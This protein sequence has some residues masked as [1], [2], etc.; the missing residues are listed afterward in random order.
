M[1]YIISDHTN[2]SN[3]PIYAE[4][5]ELGSSVLLFF[6]KTTDF[7]PEI[8]RSQNESE[9]SVPNEEGDKIWKLYF[10]GASS[11]EG[12]RAGII[13]ISPFFLRTRTMLAAQLESLNGMIIFASHSLLISFSIMGNNIGLICLISCTI[14]LAPPLRGIL[15][16]ITFVS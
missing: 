11:R 5:I 8:K 12:S 9:V 16:F 2:P 10:D 4:E 15:C 7:Q 6:A 14:G 3:Y 1:A 13:L